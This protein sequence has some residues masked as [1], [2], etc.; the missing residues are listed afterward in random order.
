MRPLRYA[1]VVHCA[2]SLLHCEHRIRAKTGN[3]FQLS[4]FGAMPGRRLD[5]L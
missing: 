5:G 2:N 3:M 1:I 4:R